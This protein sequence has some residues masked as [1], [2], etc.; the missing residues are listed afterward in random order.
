MYLANR[1]EPHRLYAIVEAG[2]RLQELDDALASGVNVDPAE[3]AADAAVNEVLGSLHFNASL[4][5]ILG[6]AAGRVLKSRR[7]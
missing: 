4:A 1:S 6:A 2:K 3:R 7:R 5:P